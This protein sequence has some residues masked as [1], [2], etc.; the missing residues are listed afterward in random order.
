[1]GLSDNDFPISTGAPGAHHP[2]IIII[3]TNTLLLWTLVTNATKV[4][5]LEF[6]VDEIHQMSKMFK[7]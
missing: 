2:I 6:S 1:M 5:G 4:M 7:E 3:Y